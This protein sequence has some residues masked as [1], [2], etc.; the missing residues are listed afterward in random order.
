MGK[1]E[2]VSE[3]SEDNFNRIINDEKTPLV[4]VDFF[5]EWCMPCVMMGPVIERMAEKNTEVK[6]CKINVDDAPNLSNEYEVSSIPC[7]VFFKEGKE[8]D[9]IVGA[10]NEHIL[11]EKI[12]DYIKG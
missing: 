6:F 2:M 8:V 3:L 9:R 4:V 7:I 1:K 5:A 11:N 12:K 10:V